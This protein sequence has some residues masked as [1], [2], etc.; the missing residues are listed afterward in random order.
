MMKEEIRFYYRN[1][2]RLNKAYC[3]EYILIYGK[4]VVGH[5]ASPKDA[6]MYL[7]KSAAKRLF[8]LLSITH[9]SSKLNPKDF[10]T[11]NS[12]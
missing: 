11:T 9:L 6:Y 7:F 10:G 1:R 8:N 3:G 12:L 5:F 4:R 2:S